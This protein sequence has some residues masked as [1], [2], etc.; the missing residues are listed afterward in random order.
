M[1][2][3]FQREGNVFEHP[4]SKEFMAEHDPIRNASTVHHEHI[5]KCT[6]DVRQI[7]VPLGGG[8]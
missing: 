8:M 3:D 5:I 4:A 1:T 6:K 7:D 2:G